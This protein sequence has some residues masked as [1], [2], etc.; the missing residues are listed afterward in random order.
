MIVIIWQEPT[1]G[2]VVLLTLEY[3]RLSFWKNA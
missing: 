3:V 1:S 2:K